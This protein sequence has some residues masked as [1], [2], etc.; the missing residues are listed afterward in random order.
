MLFPLYDLNPHARW[1]IVT[2]LLVVAN[3]GC[4]LWAMRDGP[5]G[6]TNTVYEQGFVPQRLTRLDDPEPVKIDL[7]LPDGGTIQGELSTDAEKV[8]PTLL[9]SMFLHGGWL[10]LISNLWMLWVFGDN[11]EDR[12]GRFVYLF[13]Y[14]V[15]GLFA[16]LSQWLSDPMSVTPVI[17]ASG[18]IAA[19]LGAYAITF[20]LAKV[21]TLVFVGLPLFLR[22]PSA[23][24]LGVWL[25][26]NLMGVF[27][28]LDDQAE[29]GIRVA[30][31]THIGGFV[32]GVVLMPLLTLGAEPPDKD[33]RTESREVFEF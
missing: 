18:A 25:L 6:Y 11:V 14:V 19:V 20:P 30:Y 15:G 28:A 4:F 7:Q 16:M 31:W 1:P 24:V 32:A 2:A 29:L 22:L 9:T 33:W 27:Q 13:F 12:L 17:G 26:I 10:H 21:Q 23:L 5:E 3:L 8:Y